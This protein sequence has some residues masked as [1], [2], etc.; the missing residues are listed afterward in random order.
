M[1]S[2]LPFIIKFPVEVEIPDTKINA[3]A[4]D[5]APTILDYL[6]ITIP[7]WMEGRSLLKPIDKY[8]PIISV[9]VDYN[10]GL[11]LKS[12][13]KYVEGGAVAI[14]MIICNK[15]YRLDLYNGVLS[16]DIVEGYTQSCKKNI[17]PS[18]SKA[19]ALLINHL[20]ERGFA[21]ELIPLS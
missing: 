7:D 14:G 1:S 2:R 15:I 4:I 13:G 11:G 20:K 10:V 9:E 16:T 18:E 6:G 5:I 3:Q 17:L 12:M 19:K 21:V 8:Y